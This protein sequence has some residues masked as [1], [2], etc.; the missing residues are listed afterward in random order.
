MNSYK[1]TPKNYR[2]LVYCT[3]IKLG[4]EIEWSFANEQYEK[5]TDSNIKRS[6]QYGMSC[7]KEPW[8]INK[9]LNN[10]INRTKIRNQDSLI[11]IRYGATKSFSNMITW[12]FVKNNWLEL[13]KQNQ[14]SSLSSL[15]SDLCSKFTTESQLKD[16]QANVFLSK[17]FS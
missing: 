4:S 1:R 16:V 8:L 3:S 5:E 15:I 17:S 10:Q 7:T 2:S 9:H 12:N 13:I 14:M 6:L 11:G